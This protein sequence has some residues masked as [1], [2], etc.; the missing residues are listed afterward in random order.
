MQENA[1]GT[2]WPPPSFYDQPAPL[3]WRTTCTRDF[4]AA[5]NA[6]SLV[7]CEDDLKLFDMHPNTGTLFMKG[8]SIK[9]KM[10]DPPKLILH[11]TGVNF[12]TVFQC[13]KL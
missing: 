4:C 1:V 10:L 5:I 11:S 12:Y 13:M 8:V 7:T 9:V 2:L 3:C 6:S